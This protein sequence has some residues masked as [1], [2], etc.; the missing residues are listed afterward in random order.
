M[1]ND[2]ILNG[3]HIRVSYELNNDPTREPAHTTFELLADPA[4]TINATWAAAVAGAFTEGVALLLRSDCS[5]KQV[6]ISTW[7]EDSSPYDPAALFS[8]PQNTPGQRPATAPIAAWSSVLHIA[9]VP[10]YGRIGKILLRGTHSWQEEVEDVNGE[11]LTATA[12]IAAIAAVTNF[13]NFI[14]SELS[15]LGQIVMIGRSI[16]GYTQVSR[17][18]RNGHTV[19]ENKPIPGP[20]HVRA[21]NTFSYRNLVELDTGND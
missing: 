7:D 11:R 13:N 9:R 20:I 12:E 19:V 16:T 5:I 1:S 3:Y 2:E 15:G 8:I 10:D 14:F 17:V 6:L 21:V 4:A 18:N